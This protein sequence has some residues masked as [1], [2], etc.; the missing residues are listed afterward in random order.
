MI[1]KVLILLL[2]AV[3]TTFA[4]FPAAACAEDSEWLALQEN[5]KSSGTVT[6]TEDV[7]CDDQAYGPSPY[8]K[9]SP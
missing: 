8:R 5:V 1:K 3:V 7:V 4:L 6:L 2:L 9:A